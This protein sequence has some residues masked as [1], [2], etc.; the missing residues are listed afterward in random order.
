M[1]ILYAFW[2]WAPN[3]LEHKT[4][5]ISDTVSHSVQDSYTF[6]SDYHTSILKFVRQKERPL[7]VQFDCTNRFVLLSRKFWTK[8]ESSFLADE[9]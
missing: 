4:D 2:V 9:F 1:Y 5:T 6:T 8:N 3:T 7:L